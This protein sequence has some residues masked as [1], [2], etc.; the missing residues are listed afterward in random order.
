MKKIRKQII[1]NA[2][3]CA[4]T[5]FDENSKISPSL[6]A[7]VHEVF[8][9]ITDILKRECDLKDEDFIR[10]L[11]NHN[12]I[13]FFNEIIDIISK[14]ISENGI[15]ILNNELVFLSEFGR[16][17]PYRGK[18]YHKLLNKNECKNE[19]DYLIKSN[20][21]LERTYCRNPEIVVVL[22]FRIDCEERLRNLI[23]CIYSI[24]TQ[25]F[26]RERIHIVAV[27]QDKEDNYRNRIEKY[28]DHYI[29]AK[30]PS[31]YNYAWARNIGANSI[32][33][34]HIFVFWDIDI[35]AE[36][37][38]LSDIYS[39]FQDN[40]LQSIVPYCSAYNLDGISTS[41]ALFSM[42]NGKMEEIKENSCSQVMHE[43]YGMLIATRSE[44]FHRIGG[45]DERYEGWGDEDNDFY[46]RLYLN[47]KVR[48]LGKDIFHL[49]HPRPVMRIDGEKINR[50]FIGDYKSGNDNIGNL[51]KY[52]N[53]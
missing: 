40:D 13:A 11:N 49:D 50:K 43:V 8:R 14:R 23:A 7:R 34:A 28:V 3:V 32:S 4:V 53:N 12:D 42:V 2:L 33:D 51:K 15:M 38:M 47:G 19:I 27:N 18:N 48:R 10:I 45:Q 35:I 41:S 26:G 30:N 17:L 1:K 46:Q 31:T 52:S 36:K 39:A 21:A 44:I 29:F 9:R 24:R 16:I 22:C 5:Y 6:S 20:D 37:N 25:D